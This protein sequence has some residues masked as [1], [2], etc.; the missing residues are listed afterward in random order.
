MQREHL[1]LRFCIAILR[2]QLVQQRPEVAVVTL[3]QLH[4]PQQPA[5]CLAFLHQHCSSEKPS[6]SGRRLPLLM[7]RPSQWVVPPAAHASTTCP[8]IAN[9]SF[10]VDCVCTIA[11]RALCMLLA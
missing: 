5:P 8:R 6:C 1:L 7:Q 4:C 10:P 11:S 9:I 3:C 2:L